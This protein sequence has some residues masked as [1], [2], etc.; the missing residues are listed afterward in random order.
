MRTAEE[1]IAQ[2]VQIEPLE[3]EQKVT[4]YLIAAMEEYSEQFKP[5]WI[6]VND[7][8]PERVYDNG[9][10]DEVLTLS[11][12]PTCPHYA[13]V[14]YDHDY[15]GWIYEKGIDSLIQHVQFWMP[16]PELPKE[17]EVKNG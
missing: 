7:M 11:L 10:S 6:S 15:F 4:P 14:R 8:L 17:S 12:K 5:K 2:K 3:I 16:L 1:I 13:V 9:Y